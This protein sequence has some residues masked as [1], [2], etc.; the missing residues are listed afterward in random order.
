MLFFYHDTANGLCQN[1]GNT[2]TMIVVKKFPRDRH[3]TIVI[4]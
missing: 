4:F 2:V 1:E 3:P